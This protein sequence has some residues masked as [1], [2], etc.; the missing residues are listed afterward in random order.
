MDVKEGSLFEWYDYE[1]DPG[2]L[3][4]LEEFKRESK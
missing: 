2:Y 4:V 1:T 3:L